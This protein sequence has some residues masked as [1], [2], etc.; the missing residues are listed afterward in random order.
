MILEFAQRGAEDVWRGEN[1][2][3]ARRIP[4]DVWASVGRKLDMLDAAHDL[5]DLRVL[6]GNRL[7]KLGGDLAG[8]YSIRVNDQWRVVFRWTGQGADDVRIVDFH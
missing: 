3:A 8:L 4:R 7:E 2:P 1:T 5:N 6:P